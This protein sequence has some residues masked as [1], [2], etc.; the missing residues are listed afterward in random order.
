MLIIL[1]VFSHCQ[2]TII[3]SY[4]QFI[5]S[6]LFLLI[7]LC[8]QMMQIKQTVRKTVNDK[9]ITKDKSEKRSADKLFYLNTEELCESKKH[10]HTKSDSKSIHLFSQFLFTVLVMTL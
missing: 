8:F 4:S 5:V 9:K 7:R 6:E 1:T 3:V 2:A 10:R